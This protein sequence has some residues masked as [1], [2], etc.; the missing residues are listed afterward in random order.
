MPESQKN[1][2]HVNSTAFISFRPAEL[3][4]GKQWVV[5]YYAKNPMSEK[6][7]RFRV[8]I[9]AMKNQKERKKLGKKMALEINNK[10][11]SGW[12][13]YYSDT[14]STEFKSYEY[15]KEK[16]L[17]QN[18]K[19][20]KTGLK[21]IDT[22]R[23]YKSFLKMIDLY[24]KEKKIDLKLAIHL[25]KEFVVNYLDWILYERNNTARTHNNHLDFVAT[26]VNYCVHRGWI[27]ENFVK[28][29]PRRKES[30]KK[31]KVLP[32]EVKEKVKQLETKN[33]HFYALCMLIYY[34]FIRRT[35]L[36]KLKV[37]DVELVNN[38]IIL[39]AEI[40]KN[41]KTESVTIPR[42]F[43][44]TLIKHLE[45]AKNSDYLFGEDFKPCDTRLKPAKISSTWDKFRLDND[46]DIIYQFYSLKD[47][48]ITDLLKAGL[49]AIKVRDQARH[50]DLKITEKYTARNKT[51]D[52]EVMNSEF[53]F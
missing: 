22:L 9:P 52:L 23:T 3:S 14:K 7:E 32:A 42:K 16:F 11:Y 24:A 36:T 15:C 13:P 28:Q 6:M 4:I 51:F 21:R 30:E 46:I 37:S 29:I 5:I 50:H 10:L 34:C 12:L 35:E 44:S 8:Y 33:F 1:T 17:E 38:R 53:D 45:N 18:E 20:V 40:S 43:L 2:P 39:R 25:N 31:R 48:G 26:F 47:T 27:K 41:K 19:D 49:P